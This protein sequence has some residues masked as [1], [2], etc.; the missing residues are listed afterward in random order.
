MDEW[1]ALDDDERAAV[2]TDIAA[3]SGRNLVFRSLRRFGSGA[4]SV[5]IAVFHLGRAEFVLVP[6]AVCTLGFDPGNW[7]PAPHELEDEDEVGRSLEET[8]KELTIRPRSVK[9]DS[10]LVETAPWDVVWRPIPED[11]PSARKLVERLEREPTMRGNTAVRDD[12]AIRV[13]R[14]RVDGKE[15]VVDRTEEMSL[16]TLESDLAAQDSRLLSSD[17]WRY[18]CG[19]GAVTLFRWGDHAPVG[20]VSGPI[21]VDLGV[22]RRD[23]RL[24]GAEALVELDSDVWNVHQ[25]RNALGAVIAFDPVWGELVQGG[26]VHGSDGGTL[27]CGG[28]RGL[29]RWLPLAT[30]F[31]WMADE[32]VGAGNF[33]LE[34]QN[35]VARR[36]L[37]T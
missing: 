7:T 26:R 20:P 35:F 30:S 1:A 8:L 37:K 25:R 27:A 17:E 23:I 12:G 36:V 22:L 28:A 9:L 34:G 3:G 18:L 24:V 4:G 29:L 31:V 33:G 10:F 14:R 15:Y 19:A 11:A 13:I 21:S 16:A 5:P 6:G 2:A 32:P